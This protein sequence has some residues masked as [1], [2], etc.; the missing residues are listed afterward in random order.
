MTARLS[1]SSGSVYTPLDF[2]HFLT[3]WAIRNGSD[4]ALD[5]GVGDGVFV[6]SAYNHLV[7]LGANPNAAQSQVYG[8]EIDPSAFDAFL[9]RAR[10]AELHFPNV[11]QNDFFCLDFPQVDAVI[12]NPPYVRRSHMDDIHSIRQRVV[13]SNLHIQESD[14]SRQ[15]DLY[16]YFLLQ[17]LAH[18]K[19][20]GR[21]AVITADPWLTVGYGG[22]LK[23][24]LKTNFHIDC[25]ITL[26]R[27]VFTDALVK[28]VMLLAT[29]LPNKSESQSPARTYFIRVTNGLSIAVIEQSVRDK[30]FE[31]KDIKHVVV[32]QSN[33]IPEHS[34]SI[35]FKAHNISE[36]LAQHPLMTPMSNIAETRIGVQT[37]AKEFFVIPAE[38]LAQ[39][40]IE[41]EYL[42]PLAQS[43][44]FCEE[45]TIEADNQAQHFLFYCSSSKED[46]VG[47]QALDYISAGETKQVRVRGKNG[48]TVT[49]YQ[50]KE[51][52]QS[53][54][55]KYWY[56]LKS[57]IE[58]RGRASILIPRLVYETY[59]VVWNKAK[60]V[61]G[62]LFIEFLPSPLFRVDDEVYLAILSSSIT[63]IMLRMSAQVYG[64]G[65]YNINPGQVK[66]VP[67]ID[68]N[69]LTV[70]QQDE[71]RTAYLSYL[72]HP[73]HNRSIV[74]KVVFRILG[75]DDV[76]QHLVQQALNDL[77]TIATS[78]KKAPTPTDHPSAQR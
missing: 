11:H 4:T 6:F 45:P 48:L 22:V 42:A 9:W 29:K 15:T 59:G 68:V 64:G 3:S 58:R 76:Q 72:A 57:A 2:A 60:F 31:V 77:L 20:G 12:G 51:R 33:L 38:R 24:Y 1:R 67:I 70:D 75:L 5:V 47:T 36:E 25:L 49:G 61:P 50:N 16:V 7:S 56:D 43:P 71:L 78:I 41:T 37:L 63:E 69:R 13:K 46:L 26:D 32:N 30:T 52:I 8:A 44:R 10:S 19:P 27:R 53:D 23:R 34:W 66:K 28:P 21:C 18:L 73:D 65:T 39:T 55:R 14:L 40:E 17:A 35:Y 62:E 54:H 74:D